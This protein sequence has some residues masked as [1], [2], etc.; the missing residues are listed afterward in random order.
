M[1]EKKEYYSF[2]QIC[3]SNRHETIEKQDSG[4]IQMH[5]VKYVRIGF[6][7]TRIFP[8]KDKAKRNGSEKTR[9]VAYFTE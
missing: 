1:I 6:I 8:Y 7:L 3:F 9:I 2:N 5:C 4:N